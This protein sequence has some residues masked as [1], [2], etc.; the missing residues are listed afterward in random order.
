MTNLVTFFDDGF[1]ITPSDTV[2][3]KDDPNNLV[4]A[5]NVFVHNVAAGA[6]VRVMPAAQ[7][8]PVGYTLT[9][10]SG[11]ANITINGVAYLA[12]FS[13]SLSTT[14]TKVLRYV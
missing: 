13:S 9:G 2:N 14:A 1:A 7:S 11:T 3:I 6:A 4:G 5:E 10:T 12:T 8:V